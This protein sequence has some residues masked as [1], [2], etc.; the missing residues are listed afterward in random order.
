MTG[1]LIHGSNLDSVRIDVLGEARALTIPLELAL[2]ADRVMR[3]IAIVEQR[4]M[5]VPDFDFSNNK[6]SWRAMA[7]VA[8]GKGENPWQALNDLAGKVS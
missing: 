1:K 5:I 7:G 2:A 8:V 6:T 3:S 4:L